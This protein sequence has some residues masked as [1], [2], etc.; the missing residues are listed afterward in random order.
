MAPRNES[1]R[2]AG[3]DR[4]VASPLVETPSP[5]AGPSSATKVS[6]TSATA[7]DMADVVIVGGGG[8][9]AVLLDVLQRLGHRVIGFTAPTLAGVRIVVP[10]LG[11]D[12]A[13]SDI[14]DPVDV[15]AAIGFGKTRAHDRRMRVLR[16][17]VN[18]GFRFPAFVAPTATVHADVVLGDA[19]VVLDGGIVVTGSSLGRACIVNTNASVDHDCTLGD[20]VHVGP[21]ATISGDVAIGHG[22]MIGAGSTVSHGITICPRALIGAGATV[23]SDVVEPGT[24]V[25]TPA[26]RR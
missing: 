24:Y 23:V 21:G 22:C 7:S 2:V 17:L 10:Y 11:L 12:E 16:R 9:A 14:V 19:S 18:D 5:L 3:A 13:L 6:T 15:V 20:D 25:G 8:H 4:F 26:R 1:L